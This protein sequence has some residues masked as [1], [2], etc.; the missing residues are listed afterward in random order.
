MQTETK[1]GNEYQNMI[2][3]MIKEGMV[4]SD[5]IVSV[6][7]YL[8]CLADRD[9]AFNDIEELKQVPNEVLDLIGVD[10]I[11]LLL[12]IN[13]S[14]H[15]T[16]LDSVIEIEIE[17]KIQPNL[18]NEYKQLALSIFNGC[19]TASEMQYAFNRFFSWYQEDSDKKMNPVF[20]KFGSIS[21][22]AAALLAG[23]YW[24]NTTGIRPIFLISGPDASDQKAHVQVF[25]L[26]QE[27]A[28]REFQ[29]LLVGGEIAS[30]SSSKYQSLEAVYGTKHP[31][32]LDADT[33]DSTVK[34][35]IV[36]DILRSG[37]MVFGAKD[38]LRNRLEVFPIG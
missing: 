4:A 15:F 7:N 1:T 10:F 36:A 27:L 17:K 9:Q 31:D 2:S 32:M 37:T 25:L 16:F 12:E 29:E 3:N 21:C 8:L 26:Q 34:M 30:E 6:I 19:T 28:P 5:A 22:S 23:I 14:C 11:Y 20:L 18:F 38:F 13:T 35:L 33:S 24:E